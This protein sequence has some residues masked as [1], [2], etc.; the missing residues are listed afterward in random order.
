[1]AEISLRAYHQKIER[2][3]EENDIEPAIA[4][5]ANLLQKFPKNLQ[6]WR[7]LSKALLQKQDFETADK[8]FGLI[9]KID[10]DDFVSHIGKSMSAEFFNDMDSAI[11]HMRRAFEIQPANEG[12]Q[13]ELKRLLEKKDGV[14]PG[15]IGLTRGAL[16]KMY[17]S[18]N[19]YEQCIAESLVG[20]QESPRRID[21]EIALADGYAKT[22]NFAKAVE[23][24][25]RILKELPYCLS[26]NQI[27]YEILLDSSQKDIPDV[28]HQRL[29]ELD[30]YFAYKTL[31]TPSVLDVPDIAVLVEE[32][33][34]GSAEAV[35]IDEFIANAWDNN[36][37]Q[38]R[39]FTPSNWEHIIEKAL[40]TPPMKINF[41]SGEYEEVDKSELFPSKEDIIETPQ[42]KKEAFLSRL[43]SYTKKAESESSIPEWVF[44]EAGELTCQEDDYASISDSL[45]DMEERPFLEEAETNEPEA[46]SVTLE[47]AVEE[48]SKLQWVNES[49]P[50]TSNQTET[51]VAALRDT[52]PIKVPDYP[53]AYMLDIAEK[54]VIGE[55]YQY[56]ISTLRKLMKEGEYLDDV[57]NW[58]ELIIRDHPDLSDLLLF[59]GDL[60]TQQGKRGEAL[61]MYKKAQKTISL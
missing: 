15:Q 60:Y 26:A 54:A 16:I 21:F 49:E 19:L 50:T 40:E 57:V 3:I 38:A 6:S 29:T 45:L 55:N 48:E 24:C 11:D 33:P 37:Q 8:V 58:M 39:V 35:N 13:N 18:G 51:D 17:S 47:P 22:M 9:L 41:N 53:P 52:Q 28:F 2:L 4:H 23:V 32:C 20:I 7:C 34:V 14:Q 31:D 43:K 44:D 61:A 42:S 1:M 36:G 30:P 10:P 12:L 27:L 56:A 25:V 46:E 59:L 5:T